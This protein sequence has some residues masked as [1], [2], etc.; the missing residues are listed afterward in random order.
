MEA[1]HHEFHLGFG[2]AAKFRIV[3]SLYD[4]ILATLKFLLIDCLTLKYGYL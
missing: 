1:L 4:V 3:I 2:H